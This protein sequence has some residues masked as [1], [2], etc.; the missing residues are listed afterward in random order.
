MRFD[1][2]EYMEKHAVARLIGAPPGYVGFE[3]GGLLVDAIRQHPYAVLLLDE[4]E[5]VSDSVAL[6][7]RGRLAFCGP[8]D[9]LKAG[10]HRLTL[11]FEEGL[12]RPPA[13]AGALAW[14]G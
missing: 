4:V 3:Q 7:I 14:E 1:M 5:R 2:S 13:L 10:H 9:D 12:A 8:L 6:L 11:Q